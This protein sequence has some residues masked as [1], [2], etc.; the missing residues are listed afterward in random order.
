MN[1]NLV[2]IPHKF[3]PSLVD[4]VRLYLKPSLYAADTQSLN[5][6]RLGALLRT[7]GEKPGQ[8]VAYHN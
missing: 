7:I 8:M 2:W 3:K 1:S 6:M 4:K 5:Q